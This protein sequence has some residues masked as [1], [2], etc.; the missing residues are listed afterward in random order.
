MAN[1]IY[2]LDR[3]RVWDQASHSS[4]PLPQ[5]ESF[6]SDDH[7]IA[8]FLDFLW[9]DAVNNPEA[10]TAY[11]AEMVAEEDAL[12]AGVELDE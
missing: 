7:S 4:L 1:L 3:A 10:L 2:D 8:S 9:E 6:K 5:C 11:T 12:F